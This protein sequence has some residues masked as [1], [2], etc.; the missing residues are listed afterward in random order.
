ME[1]LV[2]V[3]DAPVVEPEPTVSGSPAVAELLTEEV[4]AGPAVV[5]TV[6]ERPMADVI[7]ES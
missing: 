4:T 7:T 2:L 1:M 6:T 5:E 3:E